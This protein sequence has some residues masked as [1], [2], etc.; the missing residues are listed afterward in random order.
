MHQ[1]WPKACGH[2]RGRKVLPRE[3]AMARIKAAVDAKN[4][5]GGNILIA[6]R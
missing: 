3:E 5:C 2:T 1:V 4:E 6:A